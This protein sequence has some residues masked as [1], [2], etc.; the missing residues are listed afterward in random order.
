MNKKKYYSSENE[1]FFKYPPFKCYLYCTLCDLF[2]HLKL[3][4]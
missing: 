2:S 1:L 3:T 4:K